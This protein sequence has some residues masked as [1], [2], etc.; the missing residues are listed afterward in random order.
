[1]TL[2]Q[3]NAHA[4]AAAELQDLDALVLALE[5]R[6]RGLADVLSG[7]PSPEMVIRL[8][9][10]YEDGVAIGAALRSTRQRIRKEI[11]RLAH[12]QAGFSAAAG[13][14]PDRSVDFRG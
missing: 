2:E 14:N 1:M 5:S 3:S 9:A 10:A 12:I 4:L 6:Q 11:R 8:A 7:K 13:P